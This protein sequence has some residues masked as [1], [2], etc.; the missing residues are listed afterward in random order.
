MRTALACLLLLAWTSGASATEPYR[1]RV[2]GDAL[3][4]LFVGKSWEGI[5]ADGDWWQ[6]SYFVSGRLSYSDAAHPQA[7]GDWFVRDDLIC[8]YY[9]DGL[10]GACFVTI[11]RSENCFDFYPVPEGGREPEAPAADIAAGY[12][13][14]AQGSRADRP[15]TC[16]KGLVS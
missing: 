14:S 1:G 6:E 10:N 11:R 8:T 7:G 5:Y 15:S 2:T 3:T 16:P 4:A 12:S 13:W 9:D